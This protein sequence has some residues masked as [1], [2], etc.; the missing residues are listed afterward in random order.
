MSKL[1]KNHGKFG[2]TGV[3]FPV[4]LPNEFAYLDFKKYIKKNEKS[5]KKVLARLKDDKR[6]KAVGFFWQ[7][8]DTKVNKGAFS[9]IKG[10]KFGREL[11]KMLW[12][13]NLLFDKSSHKIVKLK[14]DIKIPIKIGDTVLGGKF[15]N[16]KIVVKTIGKNEKGDITINGKPLLRYRT[17]SEAS[18]GGN[19]DGEPDSGY[20]PKGKKRTLGT[21]KGKSEKWFDQGGYEQLDFPEADDIYGKGNKPDLK[22][23]KTTTPSAETLK[24]KEILD[25]GKKLTVFDFD[26]TLAKT[27][28]WVYVN[29]NGKRIAQLDPGEFAIHKLKSG[30]EYDFSDFDK[31]LRNPKLI[32]KNAIE[33]RKQSDHARRTPGHQITIL[34]ARGLGYPVKHWFK[35]MGMDVYVVALKSADPKKKSEYIEKK[36]QSGYTDIY[37]IDDSPK[38]VKAVKSLKIKYPKVKIVT[39]KA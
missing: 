39:V 10:N 22:V 33:F 23:K 37:F 15:K 20:I 8:W 1:A 2:H 13:D 26:D 14:E 16:K 25:E 28:S 6:F 32:R 3:P 7:E 31:M 27:D 11:T 36:I 4:E 21:K 18:S 38:N 17:I 34:T 29:K 5:L 24:L 19:F 12:Q 30:E 35:K 9:N